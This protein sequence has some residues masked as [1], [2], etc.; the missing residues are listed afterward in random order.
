M[1]AFASVAVSRMNERAGFDGSVVILQG[2]ETGRAADLNAQNGLFTVI[3]RGY[4]DGK[5][6]ETIVPVDCVS[7]AGP[8]LKK[9]TDSCKKPADLSC[10]LFALPDL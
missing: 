1:R 4:A 10:R 6:V 9:R 8:P 7:R 5:P 2:T 3:E